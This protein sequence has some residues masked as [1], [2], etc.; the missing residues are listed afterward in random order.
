MFQDARRGV[1]WRHYKKPLGLRKASS[2]LNPFDD[3]NLH[4]KAYAVVMDYV[5]CFIS[6][7]EAIEA[8]QK[9]A[10][11]GK[12]KAQKFIRR[13]RDEIANKLERASHLNGKPIKNIRRRDIT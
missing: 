11:L 9:L 5:A 7:E 3:W 12:R 13:Y 6:Q 10:P 1:D 4:V 8:L 2:Q